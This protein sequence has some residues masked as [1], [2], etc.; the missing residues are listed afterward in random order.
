MPFL[1]KSD[2]L[3]QAPLFHDVEVAEWQGTVRVKAPTM[4]DNMRIVDALTVREREIEDYE[5]DQL[6]PEDERKGLP[7]VERFDDTL[8]QLIFAIVGEDNEPLFDPFEDYDQ[9]LNLSI[10]SVNVIYTTLASLRS[11]AKS[12]ESIDALK[13]SSRPTRKGGSS[14]ASRTR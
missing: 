7:K 1:N 12:K 13:K 9:V 14:S 2:I 10:S 8:I 11:V 3:A 6:L 4:R 5:A